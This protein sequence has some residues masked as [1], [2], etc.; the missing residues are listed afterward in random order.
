[1]NLHRASLFFLPEENFSFGMLLQALVK[2]QS[3]CTANKNK[4]AVFRDNL[5]ELP[6]KLPLRR[7]DRF[8]LLIIKTQLLCKIL[9]H[10]SRGK[11]ILPKCLAKLLVEFIG[12]E[13]VQ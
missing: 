3:T 8:Y 1:M 12:N 5:P 11:F 10:I 6:S 13:R 4:V 9:P 7:Y 2:Y